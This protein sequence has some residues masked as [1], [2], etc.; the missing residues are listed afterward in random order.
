M[1][2]VSAVFCLLILL[3][4]I[5]FLPAIF[6]SFHDVQVSAVTDSDTIATAG[7]VTTGNLTLSEA[8]F[9]DSLS[10]VTGLESTNA[11]DV[12]VVLSYNETTPELEI[13]GLE[14]S[15]SR[16]LSAEYEYVNPG[17]NS[18]LGTVLGFLGVLIALCFMVL[19]V[20]I[21]GGTIADIWARF[22]SA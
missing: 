6:I 5:I 1:S 4:A 20:A 14:A 3:L 19:I 10:S 18:S 15:A 16:V 12:P 22:R 8:L 9:D 17:N 2:Y 7:G 13:G 21:P 11:N